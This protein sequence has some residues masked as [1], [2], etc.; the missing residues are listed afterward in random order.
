MGGFDLAPPDAAQR[1]ALEATLSPDE[2][3]LA[4]GEETP[5][6]VVTWES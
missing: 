5:L 6:V 1:R 4:A 2:R 3:R